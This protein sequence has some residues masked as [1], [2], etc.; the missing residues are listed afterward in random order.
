[1]V[2]MPVMNG[3]IWESHTA[4]ITPAT[5]KSIPKPSY[6]DRGA[7]LYAKLSKVVIGAP[8]AKMHEAVVALTCFSPL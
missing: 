8:S 3:I 4:E 1:M 2:K 5:I 7:P 6:S